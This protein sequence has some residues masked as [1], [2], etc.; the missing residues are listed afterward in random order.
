MGN[1]FEVARIL[2]YG[3]LVPALYFITVMKYKRSP[4]S[5]IFFA[6]QSCVYFVQLVLLVLTGNVIAENKPWEPLYTTL[7]VAQAIIAVVLCVREWRF[8]QR[9]R[10]LLYSNE[11]N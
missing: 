1:Y 7:I 9:I 2:S 6:S 8:R 3:I 5:S 4:V 11:G 10:N